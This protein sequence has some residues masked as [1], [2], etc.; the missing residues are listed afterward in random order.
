MKNKFYCVNAFH[1]ISVNSTG[2]IKHCCVI[3]GSTNDTVL[4][5][6]IAELSAD[7]WMEEVR[8]YFRKEKRHPSC[9]KCWQE[10]DSGV[11]SKRI[12]DNQKFNFEES[13]GIKTIE[14][15][16]GNTCNIKCRTC[17][18]YSSSQWIK[19]SYETSD[20]KLKTD[21]KSFLIDSK[22]FNNSWDADS[23]IWKNLENIG[24][25]LVVI[26]FYGGEPWLVK[27]QWEFIRTCVNNDWAKNISLHYNTNGTQWPEDLLPLLENFKFVGI[28]FSID[29]IGKQFE[30]MRHPANWDEVYANMLKAKAWSKHKS[31]IYFDVCLTISALN[32]YDVP[33]TVE[34]LQKDWS[35]Y[36]NLVHQP[37]YY[38]IQI[39]PDSIK[40]IICKKL[41]TIDQSNKQVWDQL[42]GVIQFIKNGKFNKTRWEEFKKKIK[43][44]DTHRKENFYE[45]FS[46]FGKVISNYQ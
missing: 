27:Q 13:D 31:N 42:L 29:G 8:D 14:L 16:M 22:K 4:T 1:N 46:E 18:P 2:T 36:L 9:Y 43:V 5:K 26:D 45:T 19:E 28:G 6:S 23:P 12:G 41:E 15:N 25:N 38:C 3:D 17:S 20:V 35:I 11:Y 40:D 21:Y 24:N 30:F 7:P 37:D 10:E 44:H 33:A 39:F 32:V 34:F